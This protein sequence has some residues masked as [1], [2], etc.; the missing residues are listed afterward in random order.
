[1]SSITG[2]KKGGSLS[3]YE[4]K[5][6]KQTTRS[7]ARMQTAIEQMRSGRNTLEFAL[8]NFR[9]CLFLSDVPR[10]LT[11]QE[12]QSGILAAPCKTARSCLKTL[13]DAGLV[14]FFGVESAQRLN[15]TLISDGVELMKNMLSTEISDSSLDSSARSTF[16]SRAQEATQEGANTLRSTVFSKLAQLLPKNEKIQV[17]FEQVKKLS[18]ED[19]TQFLA[20]VSS[21]NID[22]PKIEQEK[23]K[24]V[25]MA[26]KLL[27]G[28]PEL[29][30]LR[31]ETIITHE[32][33]Q[34]CAPVTALLPV[35]DLTM[36]IHQAFTEELFRWILD[37][38][39]LPPEEISKLVDLWQCVQEKKTIDSTRWNVHPGLARFQEAYKCYQHLLIAN[40]S[41][42]DLNLVNHKTAGKTLGSNQTLQ[43]FLFWKNQFASLLRDVNLT[44]DNLKSF[45]EGMLDISYAAASKQ[46]PKQSGTTR[47][48]LPQQQYKKLA[49]QQLQP[50]MHRQFIQDCNHL[51]QVIDRK[52]KWVS[53]EAALLQKSPEHQQLVEML[54]VSLF[55]S[56]FKP[57]EKMKK[58][59]RDIERS[60]D[61]VLNSSFVE[62]E[63]RTLVQLDRTFAINFRA[64]IES[65]EAFSRQ[66]VSF[67]HHDIT[68]R[69]A[70][71]DSKEPAIAR[72]ASTNAATATAVRPPS[73]KL[74]TREAFRRRLAYETLALTDLIDIDEIAPPTAPK[75][76]PLKKSSPPKTAA[77]PKAESAAALSSV[78]LPPPVAQEV[79]TKELDLQLG[80]LER[81]IAEISKATVSSTLIGSASPFV[82][83][84]TQALYPINR[85]AEAQE[86]ADH[87]FLATQSLEVIA[88]CLV[89]KKTDL[90]ASAYR[91]FLLDTAITLEQTLK[92]K[93]PSAEHNLVKLADSSGLQL[94]SAQHAFLHEFHQATLWARY[95]AASTAFF[96]NDALPAPLRILSQLS[97]TVPNTFV[98]ELFAAYRHVLSIAVSPELMKTPSVHKFLAHLEKLE[99][100][101]IVPSGKTSPKKTSPLQTQQTSI[102]QALAHVHYVQTQDEDPTVPLQEISHYLAWISQGQELQKLLSAPQLR[103]W[104]QRNLL[105]VE[106]LFKHLYTADALLHD[107]G[108]IRRH[109]LSVF[110]GALDGIRN[111]KPHL[112]LLRSINFK[113]GH[114]YHTRAPLPAYPALLR[115]CQ[116]LTQ[117]FSNAEKEEERIFPD[118]EK[119]LKLFVEQLPFTLD[120]LR[121]VEDELAREA[122]QVIVKG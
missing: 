95:P 72:T 113:I 107:L 88:E 66:I 52:L 98:S 49:K 117:G 71:S 114:H 29:M 106:K 73:P 23:G 57:L 87:L 119:A 90:L 69:A 80:A 50:E 101:L 34:S 77:T 13:A 76:P 60:S 118:V 74:F 120:K 108:A 15:Q 78:A 42:A 111:L 97:N 11:E 116:A 26:F 63:Q 94:T 55:E 5:K 102:E 22:Y 68:P 54:L 9:R 48:V 8:E 37:Q 31:G 53:E 30:A 99:K 27:L 19:K 109:S 67:M 36:T 70:S 44:R 56:V 41:F 18:P 2:V 14:S 59:T 85:T 81:A 33:A 96:G 24:P 58:F 105:D 103:F 84:L 75:A 6:L 93:H 35:R 91:A 64:S 82:L 47:L 83:A 51:N 7:M 104:H 121:R 45:A 38:T 100:A 79:S 86:A 43:A 115:D 62:Q 12:K 17:A 21:M 122:R 39:T 1:M 40:F 32:I 28:M 92:L 89:R 65:F 3:K 4:Q 46:M 112:A 20:I 10:A 61:L 25:A 110:A 16:M